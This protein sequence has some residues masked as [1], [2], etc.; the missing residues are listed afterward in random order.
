MHRVETSKR[1]ADD[2]GYSHAVLKE[3]FAPRIARGIRLLM[4]GTGA[5]G[6]NAAQVAR[7][8]AIWKQRGVYGP[9]TLEKLG[10]VLR[11]ELN[12]DE[13]DEGDEEGRF[14]FPEDEGAAADESEAKASASL[15]ASLGGGLEDSDSDY[16]GESA[17]V[18]ASSETASSSEGGDLTAA[19]SARKLMGAH[20]KA[21]EAQVRVAVLRDMVAQLPDGV[22]EGKVEDPEALD[23]AAALVSTLSRELKKVQRAKPAPLEY[24]A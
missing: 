10:A 8:L 13:I 7:L 16:D 9:R 22:R 15:S 1:E 14:Y 11:G 21:S 23:A 5:K 2:S 12:P 3:A 17:S 19:A 18:G 6:G 4:F 20:T 24:E